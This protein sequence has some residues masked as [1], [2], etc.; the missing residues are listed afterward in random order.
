MAP[1]LQIGSIYGI[2]AVGAA[3]VSGAAHLCVRVLDRTDHPDVQVFWFQLALFP[4]AIVTHFLLTGSLPSVPPTDLIV[5]VLLCG[6]FATVGQ[7]LMTRAYAMDRA[8][9]VA[10]AAYLGPVWAIGLDVIVFEVWPDLPMLAGGALVLL[11]GL[12]LVR[13]RDP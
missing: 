12:I 6:L 4:S 2:I 13:G 10:G 11:S 8:A 1:E 9:R 7:L 3:V 5:P